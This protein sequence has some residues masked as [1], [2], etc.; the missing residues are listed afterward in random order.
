MYTNNASLSATK[1][2]TGDHMKRTTKKNK[3]YQHT[4]I[5]I[6]ILF[7]Y[8]PYPPVFCL[9]LGRIVYVYVLAIERTFVAYFFGVYV[10][11]N[12]V[13]NIRQIGDKLVYHRQNK[14]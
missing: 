4:R 13:D 1:N 6:L 9:R 11:V 2:L 7:W 10:S 8:Q 3:R 14:I 5:Q 12:T